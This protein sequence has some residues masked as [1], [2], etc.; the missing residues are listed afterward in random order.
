[1]SNIAVLVGEK[2]RA[3]RQSRGLSQEKLAFKSGLNT[4]YLGQVE[5]GEKSPTIVTLDKIATALDTRL[6]EL[7]HF[8]H[9]TAIEA[10]P[11]YADKILFELRGRTEEEKKAVYEFVKQVLWFRDKK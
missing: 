4:S 3:L 11:S 2:I 7:F 9:G 6:D 10:E 5:R 8:D 1:M